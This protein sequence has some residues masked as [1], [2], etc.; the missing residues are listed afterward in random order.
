MTAPIAKASFRLGAGCAVALLLGGGAGRSRGGRYTALQ[1]RSDREPPG[2]GLV[3]RKCD[4]PTLGAER[5]PLH[6][7]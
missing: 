3:R 1:P 6:I 4:D 7:S 5:E 2:L